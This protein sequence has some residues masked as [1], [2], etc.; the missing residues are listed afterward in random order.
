MENIIT[1]ERTQA[2]NNFI[3]SKPV[4]KSIVPEQSRR[5]P[6]MEIIRTEGGE[7]FFQYLQR[8]QLANEPNLLAL[9]SSHHY[10]YESNEL[11]R[12]RTLVALKKLNNVCDLKKFLVTVVRILPQKANLI[13]CF[14]NDTGD[15]SVFSFYQSTRFFKGLVNYLDSK[16]DR[17][18]TKGTVSGLLQ[19][20]KLKVIDISDIND[21]TYFF[22]RKTG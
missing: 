16:T 9:S 7:D 1:L 4:E 3:Q 5:N 21:M 11:K 10:Y 12:I 8:L 18:L 22:A 14:K 15:Q 6:V 17:S 19:E 2:F 13:G 20:H